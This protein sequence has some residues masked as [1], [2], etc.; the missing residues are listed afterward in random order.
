MTNHRD[1]IRF[2]REKALQFRELVRKNRLASRDEI[3]EILTIADELE[4]RADKL[5]RES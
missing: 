5:E 2:L 4:K 3:D 1:D